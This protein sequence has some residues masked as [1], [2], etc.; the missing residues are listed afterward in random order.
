MCDVTSIGG[1]LLTQNC[2]NVTVVQ[3]EEHEQANSEFSQFFEEFF[4]CA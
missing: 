1:D 3:T 2:T 4:D